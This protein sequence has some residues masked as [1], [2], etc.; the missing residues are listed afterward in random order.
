MLSIFFRNWI[1]NVFYFI[2]FQYTIIGEGYERERLIF[3]AHQLGIDEQVIFSG[4]IPHQYIKEY[5]EEADIYLQYSNQEGFC[6]AVLEAQAMGLLCVVTN[7]D[8]LPENV[9]DGETGWVVPKRSAEKIS[10]KIIN[11][12]NMDD[13]RLNK[14]RKDAVKRVKNEFNLE[15]QA[16][17]FRDFYC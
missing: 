12:V 17:L 1:Y 9:L 15:L 13:D 14:I 8:G 7:A 2:S 6:N 4:S 5:Y 11:I 10:N 3:A 16:Q